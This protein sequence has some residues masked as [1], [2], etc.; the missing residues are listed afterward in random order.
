M[1]DVGAHQG[2]LPDEKG[3]ALR[4]PPH[5]AP[6]TAQHRAAPHS[7]SRIAHRSVPLSAQCRFCG[8]EGHVKEA[9]PL[10]DEQ[11]ADKLADEKVHKRKNPDPDP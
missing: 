5:R 1:Q 11:V 3:A 6:R 4:A 7:P 10:K 8:K 9:C 2:Q